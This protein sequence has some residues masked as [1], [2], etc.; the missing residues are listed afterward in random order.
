[1]PNSVYTGSGEFDETR[2]HNAINQILSRDTNTSSP[3]EYSPTYNQGGQMT[4]D[5]KTYKMVYDAFGRLVQVKDRTGSNY[6]VAEYRYDGLGQ[7]VAQHTGTAGVS[8]RSVNSDDPWEFF[9]Y[10][11]SWRL[12]ATY[13]NSG[14]PRIPSV[15]HDP[16]GTL[17]PPR[18]RARRAGRVVLH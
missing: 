13:K 1:M 14:S 2:D 4:D 11:D 7:R 6:I 16:Q 9:V 3:A 5:G 15:R 18:R 8:N 17:R 12:V 10:D